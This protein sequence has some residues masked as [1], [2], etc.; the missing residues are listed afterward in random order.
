MQAE[1]GPFQGTLSGDVTG[2]AA[3][4]VA[5]HHDASHVGDLIFFRKK[6]VMPYKDKEKGLAYAR[7]YRNKHLEKARSKF[8]KHRVDLREEIQSLKEAAGCQ[9]CKGMFPYYVLDFDHR[10]GTEK[11]SDVSK[12]AASLR[13]DMVMEEIKKCD[14]V[15]ANCHRVRTFKRK[16]HIPRGEAG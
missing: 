12:I 7:A 1:S 6:I 3:W 2:L 9:D 8:Q 4:S 15:C 13:R 14:V 16:Q 10:E 11:I 5:N